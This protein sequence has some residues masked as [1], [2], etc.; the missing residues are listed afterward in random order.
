MT[1]RRGRVLVISLM[2]EKTESYRSKIQDPRTGM[3]E[4]IAYGVAKE[5]ESRTSRKSTGPEL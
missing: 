4:P 1:L 3:E 5:Y 2:I